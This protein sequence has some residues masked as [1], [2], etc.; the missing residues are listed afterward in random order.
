METPTLVGGVLGGQA[1]NFT[2]LIKQNKSTV[3]VFWGSMGRPCIKYNMN[4]T[5]KAHALS[6]CNVSGLFEALLY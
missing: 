4:Q 3:Q 2:A 5:W 1:G 6:V